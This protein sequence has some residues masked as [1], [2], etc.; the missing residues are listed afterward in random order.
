MYLKTILELESELPKV[1]CVDIASKLRFSRPSVTNAIKKLKNDGLVTSSPDGQ[2][3][4]T[5][6]GLLTAQKLLNRS[7]V[8]T[9]FLMG[10]GANK[11]LASETACKMEHILSDEMFEIIKHQTNI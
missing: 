10:L 4:L 3:E 7:T 5:A 6:S 8:L 11:I 9:A 1:R 2:I